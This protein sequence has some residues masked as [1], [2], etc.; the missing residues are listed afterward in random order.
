MAGDLRFSSYLLEIGTGLEKENSGNL[1]ETT[2]ILK[3]YDYLI[4]LSFSLSNTWSYF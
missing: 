2:F 1:N 4:E 3:K